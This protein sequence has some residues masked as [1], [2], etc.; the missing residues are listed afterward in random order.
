MRE[1]GVRNSEG[2]YEK[3]GRIYYGWEDVNRTSH[4]AVYNGYIII[5]STTIKKNI[6][7][8]PF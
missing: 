4:L 5:S 1:I 7:C 8:L 2:V 3:A 6:D